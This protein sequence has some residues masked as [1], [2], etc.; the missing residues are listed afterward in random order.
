MGKSF[1]L[2]SFKDEVDRKYGPL[3]LSGFPGEGG[4][5]RLL[6]MLRHTE[7]RRA[8]LSAAMADLT[9]TATSAKD[10]LAS[11]T[12]P[13]VEAPADTSATD[14]N[15]SIRKVESLLTLVLERKSD[16]ERIKLG[17]GDDGQAMLE[18]WTQYQEGTQPGEASDSAS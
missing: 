6:P 15:Q 7:E 13:D 1:T 18:L 3:V 17:I 4:D 10:V 16:I 5:I 8:E 9:S 14:L 11:V 12:D 2:Q